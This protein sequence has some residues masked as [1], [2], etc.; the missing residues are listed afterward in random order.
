MRRPLP[1]ARRRARGFTLI[2]LL[3]A[4]GLMFVALLGMMSLEVVAMRANSQSRAVTEALALAQDKLETLRHTPPAALAGST[5]NNLGPQGAVANGPYT[6]V[7]S[8][9]PGAT[10]T[11]NVLVSWNDVAGRP[12]KVQVYSARSP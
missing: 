2:E 4:F 9:T 6:R 10:T 12:H 7:T 1:E 11:F 3:V 5:E 8:V